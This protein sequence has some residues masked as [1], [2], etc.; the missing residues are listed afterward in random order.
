MSPWPET[1]WKLG[2]VA[3][4]GNIISVVLDP[5]NTWISLIVSFVVFLVFMVRWFDVDF[6]GALIIIVVF[7]FVR[8]LF[9][10]AL[11]GGMV[12]LVVA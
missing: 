7:L 11:I 4:V 10:P 9:L 2:V 6:F 12:S 3:V 1:L 5:V 8:F